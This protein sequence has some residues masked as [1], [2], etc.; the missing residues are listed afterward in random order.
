[1]FSV[2]AVAQTDNNN[3]SEPEV[4]KPCPPFF[5]KRI[6]YYTKKTA[7]LDDFEGKWLVLDFWAKNCSG[8]I[9][10]FPAIKKEQQELKDKLQ[11]VMITY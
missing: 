4:G 11:F 2:E 7:S 9:A 6:D 10:S 3:L 1:M 5:L 8:C